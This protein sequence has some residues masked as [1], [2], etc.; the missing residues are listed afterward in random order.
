MGSVLGGVV[1]AVAAA[2]IIAVL[3]HCRKGKDNLDL[4][5][6]NTNTSSEETITIDS[7]KESDKK[8]SYNSKAP[9]VMQLNKELDSQN[10]NNLSEETITID[11]SKESDNSS[12]SYNAKASRLMQ[13]NREHGTKPS[14]P[15]L[16]DK[17]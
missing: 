17:L 16:E 8:S 4:L 11:L 2:V 12:Y 6:Q 13:L 1:I 14:T 9:G 15:L 3:W 7:S 5:S 10:A